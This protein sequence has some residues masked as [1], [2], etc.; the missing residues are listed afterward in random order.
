MSFKSVL[1]YVKKH[2]AFI[3]IGIVTVLLM[4]YI[5]F[6]MGMSNY[7][8]DL[9]F[10]LRGPV[11]P[12]ENIVLVAVDENTLNRLGRWPLPRGHYARLLDQLGQAKMVGLDILMV[13]PSADDALLARAIGGHGRVVFPVYITKQTQI[14]RSVVK[15]SPLASGH[16]HLEQDIDGV[17]RDVYHT[18]YSGDRKLPSFTSSIFEKLSGKS[19]PR[20]G[21]VIGNDKLHAPP[22]IIQMDLR[23]I[24]YYGPQ[25]TFPCFSLSDV[26]DGRYSAKFFKDK[27]VLVGV[28]A[29]GLEAGV[30]T[31]FSQQRNHMSGVETHA[32]ILGNLIDD[33]RIVSMP[34]PIVWLLSIGLSFLF[35]LFLLRC[36]GW[37]AVLLWVAAIMTVS[38]TSFLLFASLDFWFSP[39]PFALLLLLMFF[40]A[41]IFRMEEARKQLA[42]A[43]ELWE[44]SFNTIDDA[45]IVMDDNGYPLQMNGAAEKMQ[46]QDQRLLSLITRQ[47]PV[48][49]FHSGDEARQDDHKTI[50][51]EPVKDEIVDAETDRH[52]TVKTL[53][54][55]NCARKLIGFVQVIQD[56]TEQKRA[57]REKQRLESELMQAQKMEA[58]GT[59]AGGVA[60]DFNNILMGIQGYVSL[61]LFGLNEN[62]P[63][64][65]KLKKIEG[66]VQSA[67]SLTRQLLGFARGGKY[68]VK[69]TNL[70]ELIEKS[71]DVFGRTKKEV[72]ISTRYEEKIWPVL[73]DRGQVEQVLLNMYINSWQAMPQGGDLYLETRNVVLNDEDVAQHGV[74]AGK[75]VKISITD[76]GKGMDE[77]TRRRI[78]E[79]FFTTKE[80]GKGTGL[81]LASAY[82]IIKNHGGFIDVQSEAGKGSSF[83]IYLPSTRENKTAEEVVSEEIIHRGREMI[84]VVDDEPVNI[85]VMK[86]LLESLGYHVLCAGSGQEAMSIYL[87]KK[88]LIDL[89]ILDMVM[90][91]MG[92]GATFDALRAI[93]PAVKIILSSG[94]SIDGAARAILDRGCNGFIQKPFL[95][96]ELSR[97]IRDTL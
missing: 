33:R 48:D 46:K 62:N 97:K 84:L 43:E 52:F 13:E 81:G 26:L 47:C 38:A 75:Y 16:I 77:T 72:A 89:V 8:Y 88:E 96:N 87:V 27:I 14:V 34:N 78:F 65:L 50:I 92:G 41:Y 79:P 58:I 91:G 64:Y 36:Q 95:L 20:R 25:G 19:F 73:V 86:E 82:G 12:G 22:H 71:S 5:G 40:I 76:T 90:P 6:F 94:Y 17:V 63:H 44:D 11:Q 35:F 74:R 70:N 83:R 3:V 69:L 61:L 15:F 31:P 67:A 42:A 29:E 54:R 53:P 32:N 21:D 59:L 51:N 23:K 1:T 37:R 80:Q 24:N 18:L 49:G 9:F 85:M 4:G 10:R 60:H 68:E 30:M 39:V 57:A 2:F 66:Q 56:I 45:I 7:C 55:Y 93:N 28:T